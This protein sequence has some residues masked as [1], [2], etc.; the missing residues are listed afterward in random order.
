MP[1]W[2]KPDTLARAAARK[3]G[4]IDLLGE[5]LY[6]IFES[7]KVKADLPFGV[8]SKFNLRSSDI[9]LRKEFG[10]SRFDLNINPIKKKYGIKFTKDF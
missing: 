10:K 7:G 1:G 6:S 9:D 3:I 2:S 4:L 5:D 8:K